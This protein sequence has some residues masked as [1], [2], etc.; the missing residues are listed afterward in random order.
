MTETQNEELTPKKKRAVVEYLGIMF[1]AAFLLVAL[2]L[3]IKIGSMK[4]EHR[5]TENNNATLESQL[6][7]AEDG[8]EATSLLVQAQDAYYRA[9]DAAFRDYMTR[10]AEV[11]DSL[12]ENSHEVYETLLANL[13]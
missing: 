4:A 12:P 9:D 1:A 11:A 8:L 10:L 3:L 7:D 13:S 6:T 5:N 2:S